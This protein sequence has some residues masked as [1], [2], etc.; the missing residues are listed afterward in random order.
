MTRPTQ[1][2]GGLKA[3]LLD[4]Q[5]GSFSVVSKRDKNAS[6]ASDRTNFRTAKDHDSVCSDKVGQCG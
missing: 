5:E 3:D 6:V 2:S 4:A 1:T